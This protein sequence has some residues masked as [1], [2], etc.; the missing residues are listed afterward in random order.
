MPLECQM[1]EEIEGALLDEGVNQVQVA[2]GNLI[3]VGE[4]GSPGG[5][6]V[7][8]QRFSVQWR[9]LESRWNH[10]DIYLNDAVTKGLRKK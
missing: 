5:N 1:L 3:L 6:E 7:D 9:S 8:V 2:R 4:V 10:T